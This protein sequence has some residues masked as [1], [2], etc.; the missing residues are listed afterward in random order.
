MDMRDKARS[1]LYLAQLRSQSAPNTPGF[2][3]M[4]PSFSTHMKS[5]RFPPAS[6][7]S[8][9]QAEEGYAGAQYVD[10]KSSASIQAKPFALQPPPI[11]IQGATPKIA[12][13]G[14]APAPARAI[15]PPTERRIEHVSAAPGEQT[16]DAVPIPGAYASPINSP[17]PNK[18]R[19]GSVGQAITSESRIESPPGSPRG[20]K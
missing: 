6:Y 7:N 17:P 3:P 20:W 19:F 14:F 4:S 5:P 18:T 15:S 2:G 8:Y 9:S 1:D 16:Y 11:K 13:T 12:Q 10:V